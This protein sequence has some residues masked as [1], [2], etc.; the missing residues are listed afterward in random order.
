[1]WIPGIRLMPSVLLLKC[2]YPWNHFTSSHMVL[3]HF[4]NQLEMVGWMDGHAYN[5]YTRKAE[6]KGSLRVWGDLGVLK[7]K[8]LSQLKKILAT[9]KSLENSSFFSFF[10]YWPLLSVFSF[11]LRSLELITRCVTFNWILDIF[12]CAPGSPL[13]LLSQLAL[14]CIAL[15]RAK[16]AASLLPGGSLGSWPRF[17]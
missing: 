16:G 8:S 12:T 2:L 7:S 4:K 15:T 14:F 13:H 3:S 10:W 1:M 9:L 6:T 5:S 17:C 11:T